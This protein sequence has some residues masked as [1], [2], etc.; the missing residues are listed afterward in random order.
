[1]ELN[2]SVLEVNGQDLNLAL[3]I[4]T[5]N[6]KKLLNFAESLFIHL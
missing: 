2:E 3:Q 4:T 5:G 6:L 1:M